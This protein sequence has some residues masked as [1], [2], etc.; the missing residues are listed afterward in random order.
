[1]TDRVEVYGKFA[2]GPAGAVPSI[3]ANEI[4]GF[5]V[6]RS[7]DGRP[8]GIDLQFRSQG[9]PHS[10]TI[11]ILDAL[12]LLGM[13]KSMQLNED[14]PFPEDPRDPNWK[15]SDYVSKKP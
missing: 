2:V 15:A 3:H 7:P 8:A 1:M 11:P 9:Q 10:V 4:M 6:G 14:L 5:R 12:A 13:L